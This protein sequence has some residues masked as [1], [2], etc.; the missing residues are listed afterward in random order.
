MYIPSRRKFLSV[1]CRSLATIGTAGLFS[2]FGMMN[3]MAQSSPNYKAL[4]CVFLLG[5]NDGNNT[6][7]PILTANQNYQ[8]YAGVRQG[9][10]LAQNTLLPIPAQKGANTYG[11]HPRLVEIQ[12][13]Y[14][15]KKAAIVANVG[16]LV[17]P[18]TRAQYIAQS[19]PVPQNLFS[20]SDQQDQWQTSFTNSFSATGWAGRAADAVQALN[21][22]S[23]FPAV[24]SVNGSSLFC[25]GQSTLPTT[26]TPGVPLG[27]AGFGYGTQS[28]LLG[29]Q[30]LLTFDNGLALVQAANGIT[31]RGISAANTLNAAL[32]SAAALVT[33]FP[34]SSIGQQLQQ[35]AKIIQV[36]SAL[37][38]SRQIFFCSLNGFDTH[39]DQLATQ[40]SLLSQ[41]SPAISSFY[42]AT[43]ELGVDQQ[44]T[45]FTESEF[46][47]TCQPS[48]GG[49][50]DHGW[51]GHHLVIGGAVV[52]GDMYGV[53]PTLALAGPDDAGSRGVWV[54]TTAL[55]QYGVTLATWFGVGAGSLGSVFPNLVNFNPAADNLG[56]LG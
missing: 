50:S 32:S 12:Q 18:T 55:D 14:L 42:T 29:L 13:I 45:T 52:G 30:Q 51:G 49:G 26:V 17:K 7:V 19:V 5:G 25:V 22:P 11:L 41:L 31:T 46:A 23:T 1:S 16:M 21:S 33:Q 3:A 34:T 39:N 28:E 48:S 47:R 56:F 53:Y 44:V 38:L 24:V 15:Q 8:G 43:Q 2:R 10:A 4:V 54:P 40:D 20:H 36:R 37:G 35:V 6:I 27:L 9:L